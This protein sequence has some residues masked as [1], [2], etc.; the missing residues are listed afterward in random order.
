MLPGDLSSGCAKHLLLQQVPLDRPAELQNAIYVDRRE[1]DP[2]VTR[3]FGQR[4]VERVAAQTPAIR[5]QRNRIYPHQDHL[6]IAQLIQ[7]LPT[8][9]PRGVRGFLRAVSLG[10]SRD[11]EAHSAVKTASISLSV[12]VSRHVLLACQ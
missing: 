8:A 5:V 7:P 4:F 6:F 11:E 12:C 10:A 2:E 9:C 1:V 3:K